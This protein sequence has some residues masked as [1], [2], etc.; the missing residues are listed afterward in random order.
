M[1]YD[2]DIQFFGGGGGSSSTR[3]VE[4]VGPKSGELQALEREFYKAVQP[5]INRYNSEQ[6]P[7]IDDAYRKQTA[8][9]SLY[10]TLL[11]QSP[12]LLDDA[13]AAGD[14]WYARAETAADQAAS[15]LQFGSNVNKWY[16][17]YAQGQLTGAG[18]MLAT[19]EIPAG[20][21]NA[22]QANVDRGLKQGMGSSLNNLASR[23]VLNSSVTNK[24]LMDMSQAA[25]DALN[26]GYLDAFNSAMSGYQGNAGTAAN[27]G[28]SFADTFLNLN[29]TALGQAKDMASIGSM[30]T[31]DLLNV[32]GSNLAERDHLMGAIPQYHQNAAAGMYPAHQVLQTMQQDHWNSNKKDHIV[33]QSGGK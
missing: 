23:G 13:R 15:D 32:H 33:S 17:D 9:N 3:T 24:G 26:R 5:V 6:G 8:A 31:G 28:R 10:D 22:L 25:G 20:L 14:Q 27:A 29:S 7:L 16:D 4:Q 1:K 30:R 21:M 18:N 12:G 11:G 2:F 19:G